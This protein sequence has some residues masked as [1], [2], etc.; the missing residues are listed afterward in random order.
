MEIYKKKC[1]FCMKDFTA[2]YFSSIYCCRECRKE[3]EKQRRLTYKRNRK[4]NKK[5]VVE[6]SKKP[7]IAEISNAAN[8]ANMTYG[9]YVA[10]MGL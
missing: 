8:M 5:N 6:K 9:Q 3:S 4:S 1:N 10:K 7:T 2:E